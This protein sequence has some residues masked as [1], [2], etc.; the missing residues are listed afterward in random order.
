MHVQEKMQRNTAKQIVTHIRIRKSN[1]KHLWG[2]MGA[3]H[4]VQ[5]YETEKMSN[6]CFIAIKI[7]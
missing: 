5:Q 7:L 4:L 6:N 3:L 2:G 1:S